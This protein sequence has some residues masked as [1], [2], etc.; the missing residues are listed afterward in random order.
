V[1]ARLENAEAKMCKT[2]RIDSAVLQEPEGQGYIQG[3]SLKRDNE[4]HNTIDT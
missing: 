3:N 2:Q 1:K 4:V